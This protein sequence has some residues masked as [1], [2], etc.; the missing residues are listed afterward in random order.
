MTFKVIVIKM[1]KDPKE[2][3]EKVK[4]M[5]EQNGKQKENLERNQ[6]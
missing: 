4:T 1:L 2:D 3:V 5:Y 6:K